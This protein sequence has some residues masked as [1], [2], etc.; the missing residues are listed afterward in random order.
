[1]ILAAVLVIAVAMVG[2]AQT[3]QMQVPAAPIA[4]G[5][6]VSAG[7]LR[8]WDN[9][10]MTGDVLYSIEPTGRTFQG[11][12][13]QG[14][15]IL[16]FDGSTFFRGPNNTGEIIFNLEND[17]IFVGATSEVA[18]YTV[19]DGIVYEGGSTSGAILYNYEGSKMFEGNSSANLVL[20]GNGDI[21]G[22]AVYV[23][24]LLADGRVN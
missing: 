24:P 8:F 2:C 13:Q 11:T 23:L 4:A 7:S 9:A 5:E 6:D 20:Q 21:G 1:M 19:K 18:A 12:V 3:P 22:D 16:F 17:T 14:Q 10:Q 15:A